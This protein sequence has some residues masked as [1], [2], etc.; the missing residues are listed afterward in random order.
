VRYPTGRS[1]VAMLRDEA[2]P[3][4]EADTRLV[5]CTPKSELEGRLGH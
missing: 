3:K 5:T 1:L 2:S 4:P